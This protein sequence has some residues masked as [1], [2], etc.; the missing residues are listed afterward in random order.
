ML[1]EKGPEPSH[2]VNEAAQLL[3]EAAELQKLLES[4]KSSSRNLMRDTE[5]HDDIDDWAR[6]RVNIE[7]AKKKIITA[8]QRRE[9]AGSSWGKSGV[10]RSSHFGPSDGT[11]SSQSILDLTKAEKLTKQREAMG[12]SAFAKS[13]RTDPIEIAAKKD[14]HARNMK[15]FVV[16]YAKDAN[17]LAAAQAVADAAHTPPPVSKAE[18]DLA[19]SNRKRAR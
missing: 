1:T 19:L 3:E 8:E 5:E 2:E 18:S 12:S 16:A 17:G 15:T 14:E 4:V 11:A 10:K 7:A 6:A 9:K 13:I